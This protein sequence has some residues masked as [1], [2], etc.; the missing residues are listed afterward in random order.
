MRKDQEFID[1]YKKDA[2]FEAVLQSLNTHLSAPEQELYQ[3]YPEVYSCIHV[4]GA[5]RSGT[6]LLNQLISSCLDVGYV[7]NFIATFYKAPVHGITL[8]KKLLGTHY[9]SNFSSEFGK[10][11]TIYEPH[12]FGYFWSDLLKYPEIAQMPPEHEQT[13]DWEKLRLTLL[14]MC[15]AFGASM[16]FKSLYLGWHMQKVVQLLP[17]TLFI[18]I[19]RDEL[20]NAFSLLRIRKKYFASTEKWASIKPLGYESLLQKSPHEQVLGQ[21]R[22]LNAS[23]LQQ[24]AL[25]PEANCLRI[26][27]QDLCNN[28]GA[29][30]KKVMNKLDALGVTH[31]L[32]QK[33]PESF[34][35]A[36]ANTNDA[37]YQILQSL[38]QQPN[39]GA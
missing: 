34:A 19:E 30:L 26:R 6:T 37:D 12:E 3:N 32:S 31:N 10:T 35:V 17:K 4:V 22:M 13:I 29:I 2:S 5:P 24:L 23:Y 21:V 39:A 20:D 7:N 16:V 38:C 25:L 27:Y 28:P 9:P 14:N 1:K 36:A 18:F 11:N 33:P 15:Q 8:S